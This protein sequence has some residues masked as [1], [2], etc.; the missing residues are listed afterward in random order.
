MLRNFEYLL[1]VQE[2][3]LRIHEQEL[4]KK[5]LP[6]TVKTFEQTVE[7]AHKAMEAAMI[8]A[9]EAEKEIRT[10]DEGVVQAQAHLEKSEE[11]LNAI[12]T[13]RE[14]D[15]VHTEIETQKNIIQ[16]SDVRKKK[17][18]DEAAQQK[19]LAEAAQK[20]YDAI[21]AENEP[22]I[23]ELKTK[24]ASI[25]SVITGIVKERE[26]IVPLINK[27][28][29]RTYDLIRNRRK[30]GQVLSCV[31]ETRLCSVCHKVLEAQLLSEIKR[32]S[33]LLMCQN[34]GSIFIWTGATKLPDQKA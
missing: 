4:A 18:T 11:R 8:K 29:L 16:T 12:K 26:A 5:E 24:I 20:D 28:V 17:F 15:A 33:K 13:N 27:S 9:D 34:C 14:Y 32:S 7:T 21:K 6:E 23:A 31:T 10:L 1:Q 19:T 2:I 22:K 30:N 25:D 3:D